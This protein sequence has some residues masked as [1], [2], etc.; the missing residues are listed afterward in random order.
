MWE[1]HVGTF[2]RHLEQASKV[3]SMASVKSHFTKSPLET[4]LFLNFVGNQ[5]GSSKK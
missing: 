2:L 3:F 5:Q 1:K 4:M